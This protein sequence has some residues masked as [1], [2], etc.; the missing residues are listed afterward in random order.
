[1]RF[2]YALSVVLLCASA[3]QAQST[4]VLTFEAVIQRALQRNVDLRKAEAG[5]SLQTE[6]I[7][8]ERA[9]F[10]PD[11]TLFASPSQRYGLS[12]DQTTGRVVQEDYRSFNINASSSLNLFNGFADVATLKQA[13]YELESSRHSFRRT[14]QLTLSD[15]ASRFLQVLLDEQLIKIQ[16]EN[17]EAQKQQLSRTR[18][19][20]NAGIRP[21]A[22]LYQ[23]QANVANAELQL[24]NARRNYEVSK[25]RLL[26]ALQ[27]NP[28]ESYTILSPPIP[29]KPSYIS[30]DLETLV[31]KAYANRP[32]LKAQEARLQADRESIRAARAGYYPRITLSASGGSNYTS[33]ATRFNPDLD[34][35]EQLWN[36][37]RGAV[38]SLSI[39]IPIFDRFLTRR[40]VKQARIQYENDRID[41]ENLRNQI[42]MDVKQTYLDYQ[43]AYKRL[44]AS[45]RQLEAAR[46]ALQA[47]EERYNV[48]QA[49]LVELTQARANYVRATS[50]RTQ[51]LYNFIFQQKLLELQTGA[52]DLSSFQ[53]F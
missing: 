3:L 41:F 31:Q 23:Q 25:M 45:D 14:Q 27:L 7:L 6:N 36:R 8:R 30:Y 2:W 5:L 10:L 34:F 4:H 39:N 17:L 51:A 12:F 44:E 49:T 26:Q 35:W 9:D 24:I 21:P 52:V 18:E 1:M 28:M 29:E 22:D 47:E 13:Q 19:L 15:V 16:E 48:G 53:Q 46:L 38:L 11:L 20:V 32:D 37:N 40:A 42:A 50:E 33:L 43:T